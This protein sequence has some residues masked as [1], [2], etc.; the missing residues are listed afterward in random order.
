MERVASGTPE[1]EARLRRRLER[2]VTHTDVPGVGPPE[3]GKARDVYRRGK[4]VALVSTDRVSAFDSG[5]CSVPF[6]G[7]AVSQCSAW[8]HHVAHAESSVPLSSSLLASPHPSVTL[9]QACSPLPVE[10]VVRAFVAGSTSTSLWH[11][12]SQGFRSFCGHS[13]PDGLSKHD[14]LPQ[15]IVTPTTK[16]DAG[17]QSISAEQIITSGVVSTDEWHLAERA[18]L[19]LFALGQSVAEQNG[20]L[21]AD[22]KYEIGRDANGQLMLIDEIHTPDSSRWWAAD[23]FEERKA[24]GQEPES[25]DKEL[26]RQWMKQHSEPYTSNTMPEPPDELRLE[27]SR[28]Y[29]HLYE[30]IT[31]SQFEPADDGN[32]ERQSPNA[33][34]EAAIQ[35]ALEE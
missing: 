2:C 11:A 6:K 9:M 30:C 3:R 25:L 34:V 23:T 16:S 31:G 27:L 22:T 33:S 13:L 21:L 8:W 15:P 14:R 20:L 29:I 7:Q 28:R 26:L 32:D 12:Y 24:A 1:L 17:D 4:R 5:V 10:L 19:S 35:K 18:A